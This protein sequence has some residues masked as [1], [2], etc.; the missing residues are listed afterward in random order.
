[1][2]ASKNGSAMGISLDLPPFEKMSLELAPCLSS[3][4]WSAVAP[5][6]APEFKVPP[7]RCRIFIWNVSLHGGLLVLDIS[8]SNK[9]F[10]IGHMEIDVLMLRQLKHLN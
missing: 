10:E 6:V 1:M 8:I 3:A 5:R 4:L 7:H 2:L 9:D